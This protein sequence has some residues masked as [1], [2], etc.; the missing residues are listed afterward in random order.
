MIGQ[1]PQFA[2]WT[3]DEIR[4]YIM[5]RDESVDLPEHV[6]DR[7]IQ[8]GALAGSPEIVKSILSSGCANLNDEAH[9]KHA[10]WWDQEWTHGAH[11]IS[12]LDIK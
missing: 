5:S 12:H 11:I 7:L 9:D 1:T 4:M 2:R 10:A 3:K 8:L 6:C